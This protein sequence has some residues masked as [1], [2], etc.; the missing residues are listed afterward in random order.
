MLSRVAERMYWL[1]RYINRV[2]NTARLVNVNATLLFDLPKNSKLNWVDLTDIIDGRELFNSLYE[3][4]VERNVIKFM[5]ADKENPSSL[6]NSLHYVR[7]NTRTTREIIPSETWEQINELSIYANENTQKGLSRSGR[8]EYLS[9]IIQQCQQILGLIE[10]CMSH[11]VAYFFFLIGR[12]LENAD[13]A[14][15]IIDIGS[16]NFF[17]QDDDSSEYY[18]NVLWMNV[19]RSLS[20]FQ[21]Y[22]QHVPDK[23]NGVDVFNFILK[24]ELFP[25]S[26]M[27]SI[28]ELEECF[29]LLPR[30]E[31]PLRSLLHIKRFVKDFNVEQKFDNQ[32]HTFIDDL[33]FK[34]NDMHEVITE[35]W[36]EL[37]D[38]KI[39]EMIAGE[40][41]QYQ[42]QS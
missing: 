20:A 18:Q 36:F 24:D 39:R 27:F 26:I 8:H 25:R 19:L 3:S 40:S 41:R 29:N 4:D 22:R 9:D 35:T 31:T 38:E 10:T 32:L 6:L 13:M 15:R 2:E 5:L 21:M 42:S 28:L 11:N 30:N 37:T 12:H 33:Q 23:V 17:N 1:G 7:E 16:I 14:S 34:L